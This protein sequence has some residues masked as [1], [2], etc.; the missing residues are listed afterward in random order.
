MQLAR[1]G[2]VIGNMRK[3]LSQSSLLFIVFERKQKTN[4]DGFGFKCSN[5]AGQCLNVGKVSVSE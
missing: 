3:R 4:G 1:Y 2:D 5:L